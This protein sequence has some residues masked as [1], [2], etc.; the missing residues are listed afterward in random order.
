M[1]SGHLFLWNHGATEAHI[2]FLVGVFFSYEAITAP[3]LISIGL[4]VV[5]ITC[6]FLA[7]SVSQGF[8]SLTQHR[9]SSI[10]YMTHLF[11]FVPVLLPVLTTDEVGMQRRQGFVTAARF[12]L[13]GIFVN[14]NVTIPFQVL[15]TAAEIMSYLSTTSDALVGPWCVWQV[16]ALA[17]MILA[18]VFMDMTV[19]ARIR[20]HVQA[21]DA[22]TLVSSFR[23][24]LRGVC[25]GEVLLDNHLRVAEESACLK[26]L[27]LTDVS[28]KGR[29]FEDLLADE[30]D[31]FQ[32]FVA[33]S[34]EAEPQTTPSG[35]RVSLRDS[36]GIRVGTDIYHVPVPGHSH[37][38][39]H[40]LAF[41]ED[42]ESR[43]QPDAADEAPPATVMGRRPSSSCTES[44]FPQL[45]QATLL[46]DVHSEF[47]NVQEC[48]LKFPGSEG[49]PSLRRLLRSWD[50]ERLEPIVANFA[51]RSR[52]EAVSAEV[53]GG[54]SV[55]LPSGWHTVDSVSL[56]PFPGGAKVWLFLRGFSEESLTGIL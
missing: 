40:L 29:F 11:M 13:V 51:A 27:V 35:L 39:Y 45:S 12:L 42:P 28:L 8:I 9:M 52:R 41:K 37:D 49:T 25:D 33:A 20:A 24:L 47:C 4:A 48:H 43:L 26:N 53:L 7:L 44:K 32:E 31:R 21:E 5:T 1:G 54:L 55:R 50:W 22:E 34:I 38:A 14:S 18:S 15:Y 56:M 17:L 6:Y 30:Q 16:F 2:D 10:T 36:A 19:M 46:L 3:D 23:R